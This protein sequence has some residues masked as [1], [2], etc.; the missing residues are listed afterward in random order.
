MRYRSSENILILTICSIMWHRVMWCVLS[1]V[2]HPSMK[3]KINRSFQLLLIPCDSLRICEI[4]LR[5]KE[6]ST[7]KRYCIMCVCMS[8]FV[9][10]YHVCVY[11]CVFVCGCI[12]SFVCVYMCISMYA[13]LYVCVCVS[14]HICVY[15]YKCVDIRSSNVAVVIW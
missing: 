14:I 3:R 13:C 1:I 5:H 10:V 11:V 8:M 15:V 4:N 2:I 7:E 12:C 6:F 9:R